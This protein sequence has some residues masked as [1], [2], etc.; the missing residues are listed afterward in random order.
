MDDEVLWVVACEHLS[1][2]DICHSRL[3]CRAIRRILVD[4]E[5]HVADS[6]ARRVLGDETFWTHALAR[7]VRTRKACATWHREV[8][9]LHAFLA[10]L[11]P[12]DRTSD[13]FRTQLWTRIDGHVRGGSSSSLSL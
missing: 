10:L 1:F 3:T 11:P 4:L 8:V 2:E 5:R 12:E 13:Y 6:Y 9:R 7:P